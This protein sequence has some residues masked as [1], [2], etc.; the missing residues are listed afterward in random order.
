M[1]CPH[2]EDCRDKLRN[3][4]IQRINEHLDSKQ[5]ARLIDILNPNLW[6]EAENEHINQFCIDYYKRTGGL[7]LCRDQPTL[8]KLLSFG[9]RPILNENIVNQ[10][11]DLDLKQWG[12]HRGKVIEFNPVTELFVIETYLLDIDVDLL[13]FRVYDDVDINGMFFNLK[14]KNQCIHITDDFL[15]PDMD[16]LRDGIILTDNCNGRQIKYRQKKG[17][18][19][20]DYHIACY[21]EASGMHRIT[22]K[23]RSIEVD[24]N[25]ALREGL[26]KATFLASHVL[27]HFCALHKS[28]LSEPRGRC[29]LGMADN[30]NTV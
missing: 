23:K 25:I 30:P 2:F 19:Y 27:A 24:L 9:E 6:N 29:P 20:Y 8:A 13:D 18:R 11:F 12:W 15:L 3:A 16:K 1:N 10:V 28:R 21:D 5:K 22:K 14:D 4:G 26:A 7:A 17:G